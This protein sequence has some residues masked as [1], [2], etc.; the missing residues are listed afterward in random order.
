LSVGRSFEEA[1]ENGHEAEHEVVVRRAIAA[2]SERQRLVVF[3][4]YYADL[5]YGET[6]EVLEISPGTVGSTLNAARSELLRRLQNLQE[7]QQ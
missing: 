5:A 3:L 1:A 4:R 2:L 7:V 6:A